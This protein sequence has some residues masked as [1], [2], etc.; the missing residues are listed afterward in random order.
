[1]KSF[2]IFSATAASLV[3]AAPSIKPAGWSGPRIYNKFADD[4]KH[5]SKR[6]CDSIP[7]GQDPDVLVRIYK[8]RSGYARAC[9]A[10]RPSFSQVAKSRGVSDRVMLSY[11]AP[12]RFSPLSC[13]S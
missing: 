10:H 2:F 3:A 12:R 5:I 1:M 8:V 13:L 4:Y 9:K 6:N 11:V 7:D